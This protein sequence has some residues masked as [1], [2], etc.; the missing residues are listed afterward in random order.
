MKAGAA[1]RAA[2]AIAA[3]TGRESRRGATGGLRTRGGAR[4]GA[5]RLL[6]LAAAEL[7]SPPLRSSGST[8]SSCAKALSGRR[9]RLDRQAERP[10]LAAAA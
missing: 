1:P 8:G 9:D 7:R 6:R 5:P 3:G 2:A 10:Q 4:D